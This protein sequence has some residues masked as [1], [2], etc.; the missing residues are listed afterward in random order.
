MDQ[1]Y[2][3][4]DSS[5]VGSGCSALGRCTGLRISSQWGGDAL[6]VAGAVS[7]AGRRRPGRGTSSFRKLGRGGIALAEG[8]RL[9]MS[10]A[11]T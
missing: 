5:N 7:E 6:G 2:R 8:G 9:E 4:V 11:P 10:Y 3:S 1:M